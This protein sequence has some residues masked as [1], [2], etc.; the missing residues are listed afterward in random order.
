MTGI[1]AA[2]KEMEKQKVK[3]KKQQDKFHKACVNYYRIQNKDRHD[4]LN[5][6]CAYAETLN[7]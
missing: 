4:A 7:W 6:A 5:S 1:E 3:M 2:K